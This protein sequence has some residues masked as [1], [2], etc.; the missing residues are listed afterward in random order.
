M[1]QAGPR[2]QEIDEARVRVEPNDV[3]GVGHKAG[4]GIDLVLVHLPVETI[5]QIFHPSHLDLLRRRDAPDVLD[6]LEWWDIRQNFQRQD[7]S[8]PRQ[9]LNCACLLGCA[10]PVVR[11]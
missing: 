6:D 7:G 9:N 11:E 4:Q 10:I 2:E 5:D 3:R 1:D 8:L